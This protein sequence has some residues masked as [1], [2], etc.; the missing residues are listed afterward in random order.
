MVSQCVVAILASLPIIVGLVFLFGLV[1]ISALFPLVVLGNIIL[2]GKRGRPLVAL[3]DI[4]AVYIF[5][6]PIA[7]SQFRGP[8]NSSR[9]IQLSRPGRESRTWQSNRAL[10][11]VS[12]VSVV[13]LKYPGVITNPL[14][15]I[16]IAARGNRH[17]RFSA[18]PVQMA[19][20][21]FVGRTD[22]RYPTGYVVHPIYRI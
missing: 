9:S 19:P 8:S 5:R 16:S 3:F 22:I 10:S 4:F 2:P 15:S 18:S 12:I 20:F 11:I 21:Q 7:P 17:I 13:V 1:D 14:T 6:H